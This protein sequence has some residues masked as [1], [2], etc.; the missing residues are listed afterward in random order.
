MTQ[1]T[2]SLIGMAC[3]RTIGTDGD[4][5]CDRL[6]QYVHCRNC[7]VF[8]LAGRQLLDRPMPDDYR[9]EITRKLAEKTEYARPDDL[10]LMVFRIGSIWLAIAADTIEESMSPVPVS[11]IPMRS[12]GCFLGLVNTLDGIELCFSLKPF[13]S[14]DPGESPTTADTPR[15]FPR[16]LVLRLRGQRWVV[17]VDEVEGIIGHSRMQLEAV[18]ASL[19][20]S[21]HRL[22]TAFCDMQGRQVMIIDPP[23]L[24]R[25][26]EDALT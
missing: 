19:A 8:G 14:P 23:R 20:R 18:P 7:T 10:V 5:S 25:V 21:E 26:L 3:W 4:R 17:T 2:E 22:V 9:T 24:A 1:T 15:T 13:F 11:R 6:P 12:N 16:Y